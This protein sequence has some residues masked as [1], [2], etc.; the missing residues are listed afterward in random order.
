MGSGPSTLCT[1]ALALL[2]APAE[3]C[4]PTLSRSRHASL[5][6]MGMG[7]T[8][9]LIT[10]CL[11][12][13]PVRGFLCLR[14][15]RRCFIGGQRVS[16][17]PVNWFSVFYITWYYFKCNFHAE[18]KYSNGNWIRQGI[19]SLIWYNFYW[20]MPNLQC[21]ILD[22]SDNWHIYGEECLTHYNRPPL[23]AIW[24]NMDSSQF[25]NIV[26]A[27]DN[28]FVFNPVLL[29]IFLCILIS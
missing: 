15:S 6:G 9:H 3:Y 1:S 12:P 13:T 10:V 26:L 14:V 5:Q 21:D 23:T 4:A 27:T 18:S 2:Y 20:H 19:Q 22:H 7:C 29:H 28:N 8:L 16:L 25:L 24:M 17:W 11:Q